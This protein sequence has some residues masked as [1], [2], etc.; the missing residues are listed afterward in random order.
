MIKK[1]KVTLLVLTMIF[2]L[3]GTLTVAFAGEE[4]NM[5]T[6]SS[7]WTTIATDSEGFG[8]NVKITGRLTS[9]GKRIDVRMLGKNNNVLWSE[10][11]SCPG[12][13]SRVYICG[14][15]VYKIQV[16]VDSGVSGTAIALKTSEPAN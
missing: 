4:F 8:C 16:R 7:S 10:N 1:L 2:G 13:S 3:V 15:D 5:V 14:T 9:A 12:L 6:V 11:D